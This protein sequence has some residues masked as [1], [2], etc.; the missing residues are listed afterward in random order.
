[1]RLA[2]EAKVPSMMVFASARLIARIPIPDVA[3]DEVD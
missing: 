2:A 3:M 1:L